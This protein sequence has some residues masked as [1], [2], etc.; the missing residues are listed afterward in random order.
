MRVITLLIGCMLWALIGCQTVPRSSRALIGVSSVLG[1]GYFQAV[2]EAGG[3]PVTLP[4]NEGSQKLVDKYLKDLDGLLMTGGPDIPPSEYGESAHET[5]STL[6]AERYAFEK[7]LIKQWV[8]QTN[9]PLLGVCLGSQWINVIKGGTLIQDIPSE[10]GVNHRHVTHQVKLESASRLYRILR[11]KTM[12]VNS[13]HHQAVEK[14]GKGL[15]VAAKSDDGVVEA[16]ETTNPDR[17]LVGVQ[18]HPENLAS[19]GSLHKRLFKEFVVAS[20]EARSSANF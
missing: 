4:S 14:L 9:K 8:T 18:W 2:Y 20:L 11:K 3:I 16:I 12:V 15:Q 13:R 6:G 10:L 17:F 5:V 19:E 7:R 1:K